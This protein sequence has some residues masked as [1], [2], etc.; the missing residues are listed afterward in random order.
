MTRFVHGRRPAA[1][2]AVLVAALATGCSSSGSPGPSPLPAPLSTTVPDGAKLCG[3]LGRR[4]VE[5]ALGRTDETARGGVHE[6]PR[7]APPGSLLASCAVAVPGDGA[8]DAFH[9]DVRRVDRTDSDIVR[10]ARSGVATFTYPRDIGVG[11][12]SRD[13]YHDAAG[14]AYRSVE[15]GLI[16]GDWTITLGLQLPG[17]NRD[18][19]ADLVALA[20][21]AIAAMHLPAQPSRPYPAAV[22]SALRG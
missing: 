3:F 8:S 17:R 9:I 15:S 1:F 6:L 7:D 13:L 5:R 2:A 14:R 4:N 19:V 11:F 16:R 12:A 10:T 22:A 21:Q 18:P 20:Q